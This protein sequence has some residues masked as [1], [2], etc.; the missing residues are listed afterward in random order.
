MR[1]KSLFLLLAGI[2]GTVAAVG[3]GQWMQAQ[4]DTTVEMAEILV[5][6]VA[7]NPEEEITADARRA[8]HYGAAV[9]IEVRVAETDAPAD[10]RHETKFSPDS[11]MAVK[12]QAVN[13]AR[14]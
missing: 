8:V 13:L 3:V 1:N 14:P 7:I 12:V 11:S 5:T 9:G 6:T 2:C 4:N 10:L